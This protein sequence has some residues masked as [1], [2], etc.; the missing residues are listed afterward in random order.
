MESRPQNPEFRNNP[1]NFHPCSIRASNSLDPD[2]LV[3]IWVQTVCKGY[4]QKLPLAWKELNRCHPYMCSARQGLKCCNSTVKPCKTATLKKT[5][6]WLS[7][8]PR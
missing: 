4:Q 8:H 6:N 2:Q 5:T 3:L 7:Q 1:E